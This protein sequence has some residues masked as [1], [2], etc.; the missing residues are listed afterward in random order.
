MQLLGIPSLLLMPGVLT[1]ITLFSAA[2]FL[3]RTK[4]IDWKNPILI[5]V[6]VTL[7]F[8]YAFS[9]P[10]VV[11]HFGPE[12]DYLRG[13]DLKDVVY[14]WCGSII[15]GLLVSLIYTGVYWL[16]RGRLYPEPSVR[17]E[18]RDI[19]R[20]M[21]WRNVDFRMQRLRKNEQSASGLIHQLFFCSPS[22]RPP[23]DG[24]GW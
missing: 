6:V 11:K 20:K 1:L 5:V 15:I 10:Q 13:Y 12:R 16:F 21:A 23:R 14:L 2:T 22:V 8:I 18:A 24:S 17:D 9:Y 4:Q 3:T 7:S 19:L